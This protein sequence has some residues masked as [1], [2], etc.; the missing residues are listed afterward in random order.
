MTPLRVGIGFG[1]G[2]GGWPEALAYVREAKRL[3]VDSA[4]TSEAWGFDAVTPSP[5]SPARPNESA[6]APASC[7]SAPAPPPS[8]R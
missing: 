6:S 7:R 8:S 4:W 3:G 2:P 5:S 1:P